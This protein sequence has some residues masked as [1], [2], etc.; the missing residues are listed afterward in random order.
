[1]TLINRGQRS[2]LGD[3]WYTVDHPTIGLMFGLLAFGLLVSLAASPS[4]ALAK[5]LPLFHFVERHL[6]FVCAAVV[7]IVAVSLM[8]RQTIRRVALVGL[9]LALL[10]MA[11]AVVFGPEING[12]RR[13]VRVGGFSLQPSEFAKP[14]LIVV[15]AALLAVGARGGRNA[16]L[17]FGALA[18]IFAATVLLLI[19]QRDL[20]QT[21]L[22]TVVGAAMLVAGG[23]SLIWPA[24]AVGFASAV[25]AVAYRSLDYVR[26]RIDAFLSGE[27]ATGS[28][29][30]KAQDSFLA[31]G[32]LGVGP[33]SG[34]IKTELP[35]AH[36][37]F[38]FAVV[39]EE[40]GAVA[41]LA[42]VLAFAY[43][44]F[45]MFA[46]ATTQSEAAARLAIVGLASLLATQALINMG[47]NVGLVPAKGMTLPFISVGGSSLL[48][49]ALLCG[50]VLGLGRRPIGEARSRPRPV[51][52]GPTEADLTPVRADV[53]EF[54]NA[55]DSGATVR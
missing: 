53:D 10:L 24:I 13:W 40:Y 18:L 17:G 23:V 49:T 16:L 37:D 55:S 12:A 26:S 54:A 8:G 52:L 42:L 43:L 15:T 1:M 44:T 32:W 4:V 50:M 6:F 30:A 33:G 48:A 46:L 41:A 39:A 19:L 2:T 20:G 28:Q 21:L 51:S 38:I 7:T 47:V 9:L 11:V 36:T 14:A 22:V 25:L 35:D 3:W 34:R 27:V 45:R 5:D 29:I 31:G